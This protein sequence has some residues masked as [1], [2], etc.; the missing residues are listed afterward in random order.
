MTSGVLTS[1][2]WQVSWRCHY[3]VVVIG[4]PWKGG[5]AKI[6]CSLQYRLATKK[7]AN[8]LTLIRSHE[9]KRSTWSFLFYYAGQKC[10]I[11]PL[12]RAQHR[13]SSDFVIGN[14]PEVTSFRR[15]SEYA[16]CRIR[17]T[18]L[19][20]WRVTRSQSQS[21]EKPSRL[22]LQGTSV[23]F[24]H[25]PPHWRI[26]KGLKRWRL[27]VILKFT[28][29]FFCWQSFTAQVSVEIYHPVTTILQCFSATCHFKFRHRKR[30]PIISERDVRQND[31][32]T[33]M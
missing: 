28:Y 32:W 14:L 30:R 8:I 31:F 33:P 19:R 7:N 6:L 16:F 20:G 4:H 12:S 11:G 29:S 18:I 9:Q 22:P 13:G 3:V 5:I 26:S 23:W 1:S 21:E 27:S 17:S 2:F 24:K 10:L 15:I 25:I